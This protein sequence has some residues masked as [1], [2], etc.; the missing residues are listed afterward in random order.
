MI[1]MVAAQ[2][3]NQDENPIYGAYV[4]GRMWYFVILEK[5]E[6]TVHRGFNAAGAEVTHIFGALQNMKTIVEDALI[7]PDHS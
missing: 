7:R 2:L 3:L 5:Q 6:Y 4:V 1:A